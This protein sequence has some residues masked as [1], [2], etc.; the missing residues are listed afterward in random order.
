LQ[1]AQRATNYF[2]EHDYFYT[3]KCLLLHMSGT[4][5]SIV[6]FQICCEV[7]EHVFDG[8]AEDINGEIVEF[9]ENV[10]LLRSQ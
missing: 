10:R 7:L 2:S 4:I 5:I 3:Q 8:T 9:D 6:K 1:G